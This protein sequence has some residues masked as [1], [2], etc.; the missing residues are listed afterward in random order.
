MQKILTWRWQEP[1][2]EDEEEKKER[3]ERRKKEDEEYESMSEDEKKKLD[4]WRNKQKELD[5]GRYETLR[6]CS[7][8]CRKSLGKKDVLVREFSCSSYIL[9]SI[10][11]FRENN[12]TPKMRE[13]FIKWHEMS[14]W[15]CSW[16]LETGLDVYHPALLRWVNGK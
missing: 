11:T 5:E 8:S 9:I 2:V 4:A 6:K 14:Y 16:V 13:F 12:G 15:H 10:S 1:P 3:E 7:C